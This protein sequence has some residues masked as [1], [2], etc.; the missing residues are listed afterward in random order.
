MSLFDAPLHHNLHQA[1]KQGKNYNLAA[2]FENSLVRVRPDLA[3]TVLDN[4]DTQPLQA[5]EAPVE[6][7]FKPLGYALILL[8]EQGYP[9]VFYPDIYGAHYTD[10]GGD[11]NDHEIFLEKVKSIG[12]LLR[13]RNEYAYGLQRDYLDHPNCIGWTREGV[14]EFSNSGCAVLM[15]NGDEGYKEMEM[16]KKHSGK[17]FVDLLNNHPARIEI[18]EEGWGKFFAAPGSVSVWVDQNASL[19]A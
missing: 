14:D 6:A 5:L 12:E 17:T 19:S 7:W 11:G 10:K 4:H 15:S 3:V 9:C 18:N 13:A 16:G 1:S 8:R 2:I